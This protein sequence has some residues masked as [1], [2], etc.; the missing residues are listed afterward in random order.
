MTQD[1]KSLRA[2][3]ATRPEA[4]TDAQ[5]L[6]YEVEDL[7]NEIHKLRGTLT[8]YAPRAEVT[9]DLDNKIEELRD[10]LT[11]SREILVRDRTRQTKIWVISL[12]IIIAALTFSVMTLTAVTL[13]EIDILRTQVEGLMAR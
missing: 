5:A 1:D 9:R 13:E 4:D 2:R 3:R 11:E 10:D 6:R 7:N 12:L 8:A